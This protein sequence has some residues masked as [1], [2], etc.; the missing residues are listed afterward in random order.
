MK[1]ISLDCETNGLGGQAFAVAAVLTD[2]NGR[3]VDTWEARCPIAGPVD[4]WVT[5]NVLPALDDMPETVDS[6]EG[7]LAGWRVWFAGRHRGRGYEAAAAKA[8]RHEAVVI[9]HVV[10]PV[11]AKFLRD[12]HADDLFTGPF[13]L[14]DVAPLLL[15]AGHDPTSVDTYLDRHGLPKPDGSPHHPLYDARAAVTAFRHLMAG[16]QRA[17]M[18]IPVATP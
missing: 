14:L 17:R 18:G 2:D 16:F 11:E 1:V 10:W 4:E 9:G 15:A 6:Y 12:A 8:A 13:P 7:L 3:E 5:E